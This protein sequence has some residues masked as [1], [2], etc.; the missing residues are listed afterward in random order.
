MEDEEDDWDFDE[1]DEDEDLDEEEE[2][3]DG[4]SKEEDERGACEK[5]ILFNPEKPKDTP[6]PPEKSLLKLNLELRPG[7]T[8]PALEDGLTL[9]EERI[10]AANKGIILCIVKSS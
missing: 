3:L 7:I 4:S 2:E 8:I 10:E 6:P 1:E 5:E 9:T